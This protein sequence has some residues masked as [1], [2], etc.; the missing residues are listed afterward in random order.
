M[1]I[2]PNGN[3]TLVYP[4]CAKSDFRFPFWFLVPFLPQRFDELDTDH[5]GFLDGNVSG[6]G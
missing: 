4:K 3:D 6:S 1:D 2:F 5:S